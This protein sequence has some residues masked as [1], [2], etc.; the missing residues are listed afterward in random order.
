[1]QSLSKG[2][3]VGEA[4]SG[5]KLQLGYSASD[6]WFTASAGTIPEF[7][8]APAGLSRRQKE[9]VLQ[10]PVSS[11]H[12]FRDAAEVTVFRESLLSWYDREKRDLPW[13]RLVCKRGTRI[14]GW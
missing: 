8:E 6:P 14:V 12:L 11:Y 3:E 9:A 10:V 1:M 7:P 5:N 2:L 13:R 4:L